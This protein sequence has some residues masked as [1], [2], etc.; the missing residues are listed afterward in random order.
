M[1]T[2]DEIRCGD[3][4]IPITP[5]T[6]LRVS[7]YHLGCSI[8]GGNDLYDLGFRT[9]DIERYGITVTINGSSVHLVNGRP[10]APIL[11][12]DAG[13]FHNAARGIENDLD[14]AYW[15]TRQKYGAEVAGVVLVTILRQ[16]LNDKPD[17]WPPPEDLAEKVNDF[18]REKRLMQ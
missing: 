1:D 8:I 14:E 11:P 4:A 10:D 7:P 17:Q 18:L 13:R 15:T 6:E 3:F 12:L 5:G 2:K 16:K 9:A